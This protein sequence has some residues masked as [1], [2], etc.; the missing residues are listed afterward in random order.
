MIARPFAGTPATGFERTANRRDFTIPPPAPTL[1]EWVYRAGGRVHAI[2]KIG[3][4]FS[5]QGINRCKKGSDAALMYHLMAEVENAPNDTLVFANF[6]EFDA[7]YGHQRD[8]EGYAKAL[9]WFDAAIGPILSCAR[10]GD[11]FVF[12]ADHG[13]DPT[14]RGTDHTREQVPVLVHGAGTGAI[15]DMMFEDVAATIAAWLGVHAQ[16]NGKNIL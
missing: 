15:G 2:G 11:L 1:C 13:N 8:A 9:E 5:M 6:V 16:G 4:I 7:L 10:Q 14:W 12:T 3:D